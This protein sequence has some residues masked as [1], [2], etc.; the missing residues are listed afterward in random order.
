VTTGLEVESAGLED[1]VALTD[2]ERRCQS[3]PWS[4][5]S[6][7]EAIQAQER[8]LVLVLRAPE[9]RLSQ[10]QGLRAYCVIETVADEAHIHNLAVALEHRRQGLGRKLLGL[11]LE[12]AERRGVAV[13]F[14]EVRASNQAALALY[15]G[16]GFAPVGIRH[17]YY[18]EP[19]EDAIVLSRRAG[20]GSAPVQP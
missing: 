13:A 9:E 18:T 11:A 19:L 3:H 16:L 20:E 12:A 14:L 6:F 17:G 8:C 2:L 15:R 7:R 10:G 5:A 1:L 4:E